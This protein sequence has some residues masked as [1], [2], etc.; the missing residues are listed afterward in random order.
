MQLSFA[1]EGFKAQGETT[2]TPDLGFAVLEDLKSSELGQLSKWLRQ[3][4]SALTSNC[5]TYLGDSQV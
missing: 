4:I 2:L 1:V 3:S 5:A